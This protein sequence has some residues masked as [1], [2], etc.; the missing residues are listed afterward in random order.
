MTQAR[1]PLVPAFAAKIP[2]TIL[3]GVLMT[4]SSLAS[5]QGGAGPDAEVALEEIVVTAQK[6]TERLQDVP[7]SVQ[8]VSG[9]R[10]QN[11]AV[12]NF[13]NLEVPGLR[14]S[15]GG[16]S[17]TITVRG[18]G[19]GQNLG[20]EQ[21]APMY[22][23]G[24]YYGRARTQ[25]LGFLDVERIEFL[26]GPQPTYL[27]K[28]AAAGAINITTRKPGPELEGDFMG[29]YEP[30]TNERAVS[31][32]VS[33]PL[34]DQW[35][36]RGA[37]KYRK[38][39]GYLTN[40]VTGRK[41]PAVEDNL[42]RLTL[43]GNLTDS[44]K[45]TANA[46]YGNNLD[47]G[48]NNQSTICT[49]NF[50]RDISSEAQDPCVFDLEKAG[51]GTIPAA[52]QASRPD[53][54]RDD[55]GGSF[56]S[57]MIA[58]GGVLQLDWSLPSGISLTSV[59]G[60]YEFNN[61]QFIDTDQ[62]VADFSAATFLEDYKQTSQEFRLISPDTGAFKW[63]LGLYADKNTNTV[64]NGS[65]VNARNLLPITGP[66]VPPQTPRTPAYVAA[67]ISG[68][69]QY[70]EEDAESW[71][72]FA[73]G[74]YDFTDR[75]TARVGVRYEQVKKDNNFRFCTGVVPFPIC[76]LAPLPAG[77][78]TSLTDT[79][80]QPVLVL[81]YQL[82]QDV[83]L[84]GSLKKGFKAGGFSG[85]DG[86]SFRPESVTAVELGAKTKTLNNRLLVNVAVFSGKYSDLQVSSFDPVLRAF[87]TNNAASAKNQG[88]ELSS[89]FAATDKLRLSLDVAYLDATY[90]EFTNAACWAGQTTLGTGCVPS[91]VNPAVSV[92]D[93]SG[94]TLPYAP[95]WSGTLGVDYRLDA[96]ARFY[97]TWGADLYVTSEFATLSD[98]NPFAFQSGFERVNLRA[99][100]APNDD[101]WEVAVVAR[102]VTDLRTASFKNAIPGGFFSISSF[103]EPPATYTIQARFKF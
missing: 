68:R 101:K 39:D 69:Y 99:S 64:W 92:Q 24:I 58:K 100:F 16:M 9:E 38:S 53:L 50:R 49:P 34:G 70:A 55:G 29:S 42:A 41:E 23:D 43:V 18:I 59:T 35:A 13:E 54:Y 48:R 75:F 87:V 7:I 21:S 2:A 15:R 78:I 67:N 12:Q 86:L 28:N 22:I 8:V 91:S 46:Y 63:F 1:N 98:I 47:L 37:F 80:F 27:G 52:A 89:E 20:F 93:L 56:V 76:N 40:T 95:K 19:S 82:M 71:A 57:D 62:G 81:D 45:L 44:L 77:T 31:G 33:V 79:E 11:A 66:V 94:V 85:T 74:S 10:L 60:Y 96:G 61:F 6:R 73:D 88:V 14:V 83:M 3:A 90:D 97:T 32:G 65:G 72:A 4:V 26:K 5:A 84:Y 51:F 103:T 102:N 17:D 36:I 30:V 25:R